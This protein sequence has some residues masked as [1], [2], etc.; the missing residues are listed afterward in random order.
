MNGKI[1]VEQ[2]TVTK[3]KYNGKVVREF[4]LPVTLKYYR[5]RD[6]YYI[7]CDELCLVASSNNNNK[8]YE[9][10][11]MQ[12]SDM[13]RIYSNI[14]KEYYKGSVDKYVDIVDKFILK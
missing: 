13:Y 11:I 6:R 4:K 2:K 9:S 7:E 8:T 10:F 12:L 5:D 14:V 1:L 3:L